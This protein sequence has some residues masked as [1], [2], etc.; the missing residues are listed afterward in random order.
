MSARLAG[1]T[2]LVTGAARGIGHAIA[3][4]FAAE[5]ATV[6]LVDRLEEAGRAAAAAIVAAG[7]RAEFAAC[8]L[9]DGAAVGALVDTVRARAGRLD[10][11]VNNAGTT[12]YG[13]ALDTSE[14]DLRRALDANLMPTFLVAQAAARAML[15]GGGGRIVNMASAAAEVAV[16][17]FF[18]YAIAKA[19]VIA[20]TRQMA[21]ELGGRGICVNALAPGPV[22]T[23]MLAKNQNAA[24][25]AALAE[26]IPQ[27]RFAEPDEVAR[28]ALF[29]ASE[30]ASYVNGHVLAVDGG[31]LAAG[32]R[33]DRLQP[34]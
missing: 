17:R 30:D 6:F 7:G 4:A 31:M 10:I 9:A 23:E 8:D 16:T 20:L 25:Q 32:A 19:G 11:V 24:L 22:R 13:G 21:A 18:G 34:P 33:L 3:R 14:A 27:E 1:R 5:G 15:A 2:A 26:R 12:F 29:L 28:A